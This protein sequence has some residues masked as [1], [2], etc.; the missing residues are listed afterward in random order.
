[1]PQLLR[2]GLA[3]L[4]AAATT[5]FAGS[6]VQTQFSLAAITALGAPVPLGLRLQ[7]TLQDLVGFAPT[8][9]LVAATG[10][11]VAFIVAAL[12]HRLWPG[13]RTVLYAAA[14]AAAILA[15]LLLMNALLPVT[16]IG[17]ARTAA[18]VLALAAT[19][20]LGGWV[21]AAAAPRRRMA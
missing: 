1:M 21:F 5:A 10:F 11:I 12:L 19:G 2:L 17:A 16:G 13:R 4:L 18:G 15:A 6:V 14:G 20:A 3:W 9:G 7:T 8:F